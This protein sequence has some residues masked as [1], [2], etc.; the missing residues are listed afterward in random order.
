[1]LDDL[2]PKFHFRILKEAGLAHDGQ[3]NDT[4]CFS[5]VKIELGKPLDPEKYEGAHEEVKAMM[6]NQLE[7]PIEYI[8]CI[9]K[10]EYDANHEEE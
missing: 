9:S 7:I 1:M 8:E 4:D 2:K 6:A 5:E 3:G 10:E